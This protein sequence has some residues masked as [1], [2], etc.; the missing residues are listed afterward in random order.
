VILLCTTPASRH[1]GHG[2][3][4]TAPAPGAAPAAPAGLEVAR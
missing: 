1:A 2:H 4:V 3:R